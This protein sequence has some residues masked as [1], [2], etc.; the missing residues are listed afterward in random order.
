METHAESRRQRKNLIMLD[1]ALSGTVATEPKLRETKAGKPWLNFGATIGHGDA[2]EYVQVS[3]FEQLAVDLA[4]LLAKGA[5]VYAEGRLSTSKWTDRDGKERVTLN[6]GAWRVELLGR[7]GR[8]RPKRSGTNG[9]ATTLVA[10]PAP[11]PGYHAPLN[12]ALDDI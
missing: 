7:I 4:P 9:S 12:D 3:A 8:N 6:L 2:A 10:K 1:A 5:K 11:L